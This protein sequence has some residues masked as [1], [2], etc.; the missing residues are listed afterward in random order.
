MAPEDPLTARVMSR[1]A[2]AK[3]AG[4]ALGGLVRVELDG[5]GEDVRFVIDPKAMRRASEDIAEALGQAYRAARA[6][7]QLALA[8]TRQDP[9]EALG[10]MGETLREL[11]T[12][13][14]RRLSE[15]TSI[16]E[17]LANRTDRL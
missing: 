16:A 3:G 2:Q 13:A 5:T 4:E 12:T 15:L 8:E 10:G 7:V 9:F 6:E 17:N 14:M 1:F 11:D